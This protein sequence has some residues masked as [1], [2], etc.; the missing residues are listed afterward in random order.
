MLYRAM[1][2]ASPRT[3]VE[4]AF[5]G[6][7]SVIDGCFRWDEIAA[8]LRRELQVAGFT[9]RAASNAEKT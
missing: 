4:P 7:T 5:D 3:T 8:N 1:K 2:A 9:I 6:T